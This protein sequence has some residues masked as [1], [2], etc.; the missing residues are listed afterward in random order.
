MLLLS[1]PA[2]SGKTYRLLDQFRTALRCRD[3]RVRLLTPTATLAQHLQNQLAR[4]GFVFR[5]GLIQTLSHFVDPFAGVPKVSEPL[6]YLIVEQAA[7]RV[8][9]PDFA[10]VVRLPGFCAALARTIE[11]LS[12]AGCDAERLADVLGRKSAAPLGAAFLAVYRE[13]DR[14][15]LRRGL[16]MRSQRLLQAA[17]RIAREGLPAVRTI[18]LDGF[19]ALP[20]PELAVIA[21]MCRHADVTLTLPDARIT[22]PT[23]ERLV[24][25]G[26]AEEVSRWER[27]QPRI[28]LCEAPSIEREADEIARRILQQAAAGRPFREMGVIVRSQE[29]YEP[30]LRATFDRFGVPARFYFGA[31]LSQH[32]LVRY[33]AGAVDA[34]LGG[35][36]HAEM[37]AALRLAPGLACD[38]FDFAVRSELPGRGLAGLQRIA[39]G[40]PA[41][42]GLLASFQKLE[43]WP[44]LSLVPTD[45]AVRL[46]GLRALF[47]PD[48]PEP[49]T[50]D[51]AEM[52]RSQA[53]V[54]ALFD[55]AM[56]EA[57]HALGERAVPLRE[58][59]RAAKSVLRLTPLRVDDRRRNVVHVLGAHE[60]RQWQLPVVFVCGL[61]EKQF[62]QF[63][64]QEPFFPEAAR[65]Q[66]K[67]AGIRLRTAADFETEE[68]FLF[69]WAVT[70]ATEFLTL[71]YPRFDA[72]GQQNLP[73]LY[74]EGVAA[75][76]VPCQTVRPLP[77][78]QGGAAHPSPVIASADLL[79]VLA[80]RHR[81]FRP[82]ALE[83]FLQCPFQF[84]GRHTLALEKAPVRPEE[85]LNFMVEGTIVHGVLAEMAREARPMEEVFDRV[86]RRVCD[87][88]RIPRSYRTEACHERLLADLRRFVADTH[89]PPE[90]QTRTEQKFQFALTGGVEIKGRIDRL[91]VTP[92][93]GAFVIDYKYS[94]VQ[95]TKKRLDEENHLQPQ[96]YVLAAERVFGLPVAGMFYCGLRGE[97]KW[98]G[99]SEH[100]AVPGRPFPPQWIEQAIE[101]TLR[102]TGEI[103]AGQ[104]A[105]HPADPE[106]CPRCDYRD[107]CRIEAAA[108]LVEE[109]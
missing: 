40:M 48:R 76:P 49:A 79:E 1:G 95:N 38:E 83:S 58:F 7:R 44:A 16:A 96:L 85:R 33:L 5:P 93:G 4:D 78:R 72:R 54:L 91:D 64:A 86:F 105:P 11:E 84:F 108:T 77:G 31:D 8:N 20:D 71:S 107:V 102:V 103:R 22:A 89:W 60:A 36:D 63:H 35:W 13:V 27:A 41:V 59:W 69:D 98:A 25:L 94:G 21:A 104:V 101:T 28:E 47:R 67:Q 29:L 42:I 90:F 26:F 88:E 17:G 100:P 70:R 75:A 43:P 23:R 80:Q 34:M 45:W 55:E 14:E 66:L 87:Q 18:W 19:Y 82:T 65:A 68:R 9:H 12:S 92:D 39:E 10:R 24:A 37:L 106:Q 99:W 6:L 56:D 2:G 50:Y 74:L 46:K 53:T 109:A 61:V 97:V 62:P 73:S 52:W 3:S 57:A 51:T 30:I 15:L 32:A 81:V